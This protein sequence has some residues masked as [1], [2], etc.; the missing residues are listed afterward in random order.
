MLI[1]SGGRPIEIGTPE[2]LREIL[3]RNFGNSTKTAKI[4]GFQSVKHFIRFCRMHKD[5]K[6]LL[7]G[8]AIRREVNEYWAEIGEKSIA[9]AAANGDVRAIA[10]IL[11]DK[12]ADR[13]WG[14]HERDMAKARLEAKQD[15]EAGSVRDLVALFKKPAAQTADLEKPEEPPS[16]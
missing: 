15:A 5:Y 7:D 9:K 14:S 3:V 16:V 12:C 8:E 4:V 2:E 11:N 1:D 13:G 10:K 6:P